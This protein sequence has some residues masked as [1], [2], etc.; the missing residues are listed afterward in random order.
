VVRKAV[1]NVLVVQTT[2]HP[3]DLEA[4]TAH[5]ERDQPQELSPT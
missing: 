5:M 4:I 3:D 1:C 2:R